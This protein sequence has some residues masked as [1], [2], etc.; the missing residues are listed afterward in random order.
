MKNKVI[1]S[2]SDKT[3]IFHKW[4]NSKIRKHN[5]QV[6]AVLEY[7][8]E[9][10]T[11]FKGIDILT[12][13]AIA[14]I[15]SDVKEKYEG[16]YNSD[17]PKIDISELVLVFCKDTW[18][19]KTEIELNLLYQ[20]GYYIQ[21]INQCCPKLKLYLQ[22]SM[23]KTFAN[24]NQANVFYNNLLNILVDSVDTCSMA[25]LYNTVT[26]HKI[27]NSLGDTI[28]YRYRDAFLY[29]LELLSMGTCVS[30]MMFI[31]RQ[32][33][34][35][36]ED[37]EFYSIVSNMIREFK[38]PDLIIDKVR[39]IYDEFYSVKHGYIKDDLL[40]AMFI[41]V[42]C[43]KINQKPLSD[44]DSK[45][46]D[47]DDEK[48]TD[49]IEL[50]GY[51]R[52]W[53][54]A[55]ADTHRDLDINRYIIF[56]I[57]NSINLDDFDLFFEALSMTKEYVSLY[58]KN[59]KYNNKVS[60][61]ER[62]LRGDF[63]KEKA[64]LDAKYSLNNISTGPQFEI[65]L[66]KLFKDLGYKTKHNGKAGD[67]GADLILKKDNY[68]YVVQAKYYSEKL[69]NTPVQEI[70]GALKYYNANQGVVVTNSSFTAGARELAKANNVILID[71]K[72][73]K[74]LVDSVFEVDHEEDVLK[75]F[76]IR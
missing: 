48:Y 69:S 32:V 19:F 2:E 74:K 52:R 45:I 71:G 61:K 56:K 76:E 44:K 66:S 7:E 38:E 70:V 58:S 41:V 15:V 8:E 35:L 54:Y 3:D 25:K 49:F 23:R 5:A 51:I 21:K 65:Y 17:L 59:V 67:Q 60:D 31:N 57:T 63:K 72:D 14:Q 28:D 4:R 64:Q 36:S 73:L 1:I 11:S 34:N 18:R 39:P 9:I 29:L 75:S 30:K 33:L 16:A 53:L 47:I 13:N 50:D 42:L 55:L 68:I 37:D 26:T 40:F 43:N 62:Y 46:L 10:K 27:D 12:L 6:M 24:Q 22:N 20:K